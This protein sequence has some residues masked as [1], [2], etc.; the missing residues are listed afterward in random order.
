MVSLGGMA[1]QGRM[2]SKDLPAPL[3]PAGPPGPQ[4]GGA[5]YTRWGKSSCPQIAGTELLYSGITGG[6]DNTAQGGGA[7]HLCMPKVPEYSPDL[8]YRSGVNGHSLIMVQSMNTL[9]K[10]HIMHDVPCAVCYVS[11][12]PHCSHDP[13]QGQLP[14]NLDQGVLWLPHG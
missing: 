9:Y 11:T 2:G 6:T 4:S 13:S 8:T 7:N 10:D 12:R 3:D 1:P 14:S 5:I